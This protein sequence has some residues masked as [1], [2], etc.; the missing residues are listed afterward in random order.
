M[1]TTYPVLLEAVL[2]AKK[3][4]LDSNL[5]A[6][7]ALEGPSVVRAVHSQTLLLRR[8]LGHDGGVLYEGQRQDVAVRAIVACHEA[9]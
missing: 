8:R 4:V 7:R 5:E 3:A 9:L 1:R 2:G 6:R